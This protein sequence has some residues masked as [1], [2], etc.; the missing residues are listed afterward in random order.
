MKPISYTLQTVALTG[1]LLAIAMPATLAARPLAEGFPGGMATQGIERLRL[2]PKAEVTRA[3]VAPQIERLMEEQAMPSITIVLF[4]RNDV[5]WAESFGYSN[6]ATRTPATLDTVYNTGSTFKF[7]VVSAVMQLVEQGRISLDAPVN[8]YLTHKIDDFAEE[9]QPLTLRAMLAHRAG[10]PASRPVPETDVWSRTL[11]PADDVLLSGLAAVEQPGVRYD[12]CNICFP[13]YAEV[14]R[15]V[16][17]QSLEDYLREHILIP[18]GTRYTEPFY[19]DAAAVAAMAVPYGSVGDQPWPIGHKFLQAPYSGDAYMRPL[20]MV[21]LLQPFLNEGSL[22]NGKLLEPETVRS[23]IMPQY[24]SDFSLGFL[25]QLENGVRVLS[26]DGGIYGGSTVYQ[27]EPES[28]IGVYI[29][30][31]SNETTDVL[32]RLARRAREL[33]R[34]GTS[35]TEIAFPAQSGPGPAW[36][37]DQQLSAL[38]GSYR[39]EGDGPAVTIRR[40]GSQLSL[41]NPA[42]KRLELVMTGPDQGVL[43]ASNEEVTF[44]RGK[45]GTGR[46]LQLVGNGYSFFAIRQE[47]GQT[48]GVDPSP[49]QQL[50]VTDEVD[51]GN[52]E[53]G[54]Y[55]GTG[56]TFAVI[57]RSG[58]G[59]AYSIADGRLGKIGQREALVQCAG[60]SVLAD[61]TMRWQ[62]ADVTETDTQ[63]RSDEITLAGRL[64]EPAGADSTTPLLVFAH[65]SEDIGWIERARDPYQMVGRGISVFVYDKRGTGRSGGNYT[66]NFPKLAGDLVAASQEAKRLANGR[67][68]RFG[69][70]GLSQGGW[71]APLAAKRAQADFIG[72]GY[73]LVADIREEDAAQVQKELRDAG[74]PE[75]VL[76][77]ARQITDVTARIA[78]SGYTDGLDEL[79][80]IQVRYG[81][82]P[83]FAKIRGGYSGV[84]LGMSAEDLRENGVPQFNDLDI[85]WSLSPMEAMRDVDVPQL[86]VLAGEDREAPIDLTLSR[87][88]L[89]RQE[90]KDI[91]IWIFP[92]T[93]HGMREFIAR[94]DGSRSYLQV[95]SGYYDLMADWAKG[96]S[97]GQYG[98]ASNIE[99]TAETA[100]SLPDSGATNPASGE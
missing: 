69:L 75:T 38:A 89:L 1:A 97:L 10:L 35:S 31:N 88:G 82:E 46:S 68:G 57:T 58:D 26:W 55:R 94:D 62:K 74:Y 47:D 59:F 43:V 8:E 63:F 44:V 7:V 17:G 76:A 54:I 90:G 51:P 36:L 3:D 40:M 42:G 77:A 41:T 65:G 48:I 24:D 66:Q 11:P 23:M 12:Y 84:F 18:A 81:A 20:D 100:G 50:P 22:G 25:S 29:A 14:V 28:G 92:D 98:R 73:G 21:R 61:G 13:V 64:I 19:P 86:W 33:A 78:T 83:W 87:L 56:G 96:V 72:I 2:T 27:I 32:R 91:A 4:D 5:L 45:D 79:T 70:V 39:I 6:L 49:A 52:C 16:T 37:S 60:D 71:I 34:M 67:F 30:S 99:Q 85:D 93:D 95:T 15:N 80:E 53:V 9:G